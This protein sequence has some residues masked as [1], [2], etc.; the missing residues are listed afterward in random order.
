MASARDACTSPRRC[1][2]SN[3]H[4]R[5]Y[6]VSCAYTIVGRP[7]SADCSHECRYMIPACIS[8]RMQQCAA[9]VAL[10]AER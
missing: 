5:I 6:D 2:R 1:K 9:I 10:V 7:I 4:E 8:N 3:L